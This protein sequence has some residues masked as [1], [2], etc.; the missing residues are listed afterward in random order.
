[1]IPGSTTRR[2]VR[3]IGRLLVGG[4]LT[5]AAQLL[6]AAPADAQQVT[7]SGSLGYLEGTYGYTD[8]SR[9]LVLVNTLSLRFDAWSIW[10]DVPM[11]DLSGPATRFAGGRPL[12]PSHGPGD[13][14]G[15]GDGGGGHGGGGG[16]GG[17][18]GVSGG[19][20]SGGRGGG[21]S[22]DASDEQGGGCGGDE[23]VDGN[24]PL[25]TAGVGDPLLGIQLELPA[26]DGR[27]RLYASVK[28]PANG[29]NRAYAT[30]EWDAGAGLI[31]RRAVGRWHGRAEA[32]YW[33]LGDP[34][35]SDLRDPWAARLEARRP[36]GD[37]W[38]TLAG[39]AVGETVSGYGAAAAVEL[40]LH[41]RLGGSA[42]LGGVLAAGL[43][44]AAPDLVV[45]I[46]WS[47]SP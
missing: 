27:L 8:S 18:G 30:G 22:G 41:R 20:G 33:V 13:N 10:V 19:G 25:D 21:G 23:C 40:G 9:G 34:P 37:W 14:G 35:E 6:V 7:W 32:A 31:Y 45:C 5:I 44:D 12:P 39:E 4:G 46:E 43:T 15:N 16:G 28:V 17:G 42:S 38:A 36:F 29:A 47:W 11:L 3:R 26:G 2:S 24:E 1:M